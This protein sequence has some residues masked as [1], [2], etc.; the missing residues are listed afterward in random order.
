L[1]WQARGGPGP[2]SRP[3]RPRVRP[4]H[5]GALTSA[6]TDPANQSQR[7]SARRSPPA[8]RASP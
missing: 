6:L 3:G 2:P 1:L 7:V 8:G 5:R 4:G